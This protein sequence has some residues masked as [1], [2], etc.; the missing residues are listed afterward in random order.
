M[1][2]D[3]ITISNTES[4]NDTISD[5]QQ[6]EIETQEETRE[7][8]EKGIDLS[9][10]LPEEIEL[11]KMSGILIE[12]ADDD[13]H[14]EQSEST[15]EEDSGTKEKEKEEEVAIPTFEEAEQDESLVEKYDANAK[16]FY[17]KWKNE[18]H[19]KLNMN[20]TSKKQP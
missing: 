5:E 17:W 20:V 4:N 2:D 3:A 7:T 9:G 10:A 19:K 16:A 1:P 15:T 8:E 18:K 12:E 14:T 11:A 13:E 6:F